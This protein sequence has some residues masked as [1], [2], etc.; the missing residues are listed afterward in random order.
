MKESDW[1]T[2][3]SDGLNRITQT[4]LIPF[5]LATF[6]QVSFTAQET[7]TA[8]RDIN[9]VHRKRAWHLENGVP[10]FL[11]CVTLCF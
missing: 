2:V 4:I 1:S 9:K 8:A 10:S 7:K 3:S 5:Y 11:M 6:K